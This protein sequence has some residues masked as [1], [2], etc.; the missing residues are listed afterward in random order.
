MSGRFTDVLIWEF[1][2]LNILEEK[3]KCGFSINLA[4]C[5]VLNHNIC[6]AKMKIRNKNRTIDL[7]T[8]KKNIYLLLRI[9]NRQEK[10]P[11]HHQVVR[12]TTDHY[13]E[14]RL[15]VPRDGVVSWLRE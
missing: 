12:D 8:K 4:D 13:Q 1:Y 7:K 6:I 11:N 5:P 14:K 9:E 2:G 15:L 3:T 10:L